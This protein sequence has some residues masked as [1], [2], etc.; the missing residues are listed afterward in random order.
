MKYV[1]ILWG[2]DAECKFIAEVFSHE[3]T[4]EKVLREHKEDDPTSHYWIQV[5]AVNH[6][7]E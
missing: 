3:T 4:A 7:S 1:W 5:K 2:A 6:D